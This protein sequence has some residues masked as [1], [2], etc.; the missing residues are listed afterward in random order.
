M[1]HTFAREELDGSI[2]AYDVTHFWEA[3]K[4]LPVITMD[5]TIPLSCINHMVNA[6]DAEDWYRVA[7]ADLSYPIIVND[8]NGVLDGCHRTMKAVLLGHTT[9]NVVRLNNLPP[10][11]KV[12]SNWED[13]DANP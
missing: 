11:I 4:N 13:Y 6:Y 7:T 9:V 8:I 1:S 12:W 5:I 3:V 10:P 2:H